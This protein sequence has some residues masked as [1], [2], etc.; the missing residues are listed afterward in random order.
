LRRFPI[1]AGRLARRLPA[2]DEHVI[3]TIAARMLC[4]RRA[5]RSPPTAEQGERPASAAL[6]IA[7]SYGEVSP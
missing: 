5:V 4:P 3:A 7:R 1:F 6:V 2:S